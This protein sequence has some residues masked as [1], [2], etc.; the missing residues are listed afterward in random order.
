LTTTDDGLVPTEWPA[1]TN[2]D[3]LYLVINET[4]EVQGRYQPDRIEIFSEILD[5]YKK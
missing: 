3:Q 1:F 5:K 2:E 4:M